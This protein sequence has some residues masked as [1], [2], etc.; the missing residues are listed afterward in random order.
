VQPDPVGAQ[1]LAEHHA[2]IDALIEALAQQ[3]DTDHGGGELP[4]RIDTHISSVLLAGDDAWK[5]KKP[6]ALGFLDFASAEARRHFCEE[7]LRLNRRTAPALYL[8]VHPVIGPAEA[9]TF[10]PALAVGAAA[11][12]GTLDWVLHMRRFDDS[13]LLAHLADRGELTAEVVERLAERL[14]AF[15]ATL[16][17]AITTDTA[18]GRPEVTLRWVRDNLAAVAR[19]APAEADRQRIAALARWS[20]ECA[21]ALAPRLA[22]RHAAGRVRECHG[23]AH[24]ANWVLIGDDRDGEPVAFD[25]LE[26]NPELRWIDVAA[27]LAFPW[28]D[29]LAHGQPALAHR[30]LTRWLELTGDFDALG[31]LRWQ[32]V[33]R[34]LVRVKVAWIHA[35]EPDVPGEVRCAEHAAAAQG[36]ALAERLAAPAAPRLIV[37]WGLSGSGKSTVARQIAEALGAVW[38]RSDVERKRLYGLAPTDRPGEGPGQVPAATLYGREATERTYTR[39][40][41][42]AAQAL[43]DGW[44]VVVD[45]ACLHAHERRALMAV[46]AQAGVPGHLLECRAPDPVL[47]ERIARRE[48][49]G[50]DASDAGVAVLAFQQR[51]REPFDAAELAGLASCRAEVID[52]QAPREV[53]AARCA[54]W[55][56]AHCTPGPQA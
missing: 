24:L 35:G 42:T 45:A 31:L 43:A 28:M 21:A 4:R 41:A 44:A 22:Q 17:A 51:V 46:A 25:A 34:A 40:Q 29:L 15:H 39:L 38:L 33:Y 7:E 1:A 6:L 20:E 11:P 54:D 52:T 3:L 19:L 27:E 14:V 47:R 13:R 12:P 53:L 36:Q 23:D 37:T 5:L 49:E 16:P 30:L 32:A 50:R 56:S 18:T 9:P 26:F 48:A 8:G 55:A 2:L 10:G